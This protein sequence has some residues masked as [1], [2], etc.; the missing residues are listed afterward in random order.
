[1]VENWMLN[2]VRIVALFHWSWGVDNYAIAVSKSI[3]RFTATETWF[4]FCILQKKSEQNTVRNL[5]F[6]VHPSFRSSVRTYVTF[7]HFTLV[8]QTNLIIILVRKI[9]FYKKK[10]V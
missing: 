9:I 5:A 10:M 6:C 8:T 3:H 1:M 2:A 7:L 4:F